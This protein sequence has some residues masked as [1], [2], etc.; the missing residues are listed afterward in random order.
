LA[1]RG[2]L[3]LAIDDLQ[4]GDADSAALLAE[5][6]RPPDSPALLLVACYRSEDVATSP[7]LQALLTA[8]VGQGLSADRRELAVGPLAEE[9]ARELALALLD[10]LDPSARERAEAVARESG[11]NPLFT[12][13]LARS[14]RGAAGVPS[15]EEVLWT[16]V[17]GL[18]GEARHLLEV[19][20]VAGTPLRQDEAW[21]AAGL[22]AAQRGT[23]ALLHAARLLRSTGLADTDAVEV[24]HD[25]IR[26]TVVAR[27]DPAALR[28]HH[29]RLARTAE[30]SGRAE[31]EVLARH[32]LGAGEPAR[33]GHFYTLAARRAAEALAFERA[34]QLFRQA[35]E[36][37]PAG[38]PEERPLRTQLG[39]A[40]ANAGRGGEAAHE[41][42]SA[43]AGAAPGEALELQR[44]A[45]LQLLLSGH[46]DQGVEAV[47]PVLSAIGLPL[48]RTPGRALVSLLVHRS[49]LWLRG[50]RFRERAT[51][52]AA[53]MHRID[54]AW[55]VAVGLAM[56]DT[57]R[58]ADIQTRNLLL[59]LRTGEPYRIARALALEGGLLATLGG[60]ARRR[61][62]QYLEAAEA[63]S[64]RLGHPH[65]VG[66][67]LLARGMAAYLDEGWE[68]ALNC[69]DRADALFRSHCTGVTWELDTAHNIG[70]WS[71]SRKG[72]VAE[73]SRRWPLLFQEAQERGDLYAATILGT[74]LMAV[75][76][77][78]AG[79]PESAREQL[80]LAL[81][82]WSQHGYHVQHWNA[83][84]AQVLIELYDGNGAGAWAH[85]SEQE[86]A[87]AA[88]LLVRIEDFRVHMV[89]M[90][91]FSALAAALSAAHPGPLLR[92]AER[93][94]RQLERET[95][96]LARASEQYIR[97]AT[98]A[99]RGE[100]ATARAELAG[101]AD[102]FAVLDMR[103][104]AAAMR[105]RLGHLTGGEQG[106]ALIAQADSWMRG[107]QI[108]DPVRLTS[109]F[110]PGFSDEEAG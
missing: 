42:R 36:L 2:P 52:P 63:L 88:S 26:E 50:L 99:R 53:D 9:E 73:L 96:P 31:P 25:R 78:A 108:Q 76:R 70:L 11:G 10:L 84:R 77:L 13:E 72:E 33:A 74:Y 65:A 82:Q 95:K 58:G 103:L 15:L 61:A 16:R 83:L 24:Y 64:G 104:L 93:A 69:C 8:P 17:M 62:A 51:A 4:W 21:A 20:A 105:R 56:T 37:R 85:V 97:A 101:A 30:E 106:R 6:L 54:T 28:G 110:A 66:L 41:Y 59:A 44:R 34:A 107:Q 102:R 79:D 3:V 29:G 38:D 49:L 75:V 47:C 92:A 100:S 98:A 57:I 67:T 46:V 5:L 60:R 89:Q 90:R 80:R 86:P 18:A 55:S 7:C 87:F 48:A 35:L 94:A 81:G 40:L 22:A 14:A 27:L 19:V 12:H 39:D 71:L 68:T 1:A 109:A 23:L 45:A 91:A 32:F 43:A